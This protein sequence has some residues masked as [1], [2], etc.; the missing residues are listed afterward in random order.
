[1]LM[2]ITS[3]DA[4]A[5]NGI[6]IL[7]L[8][9]VLIKA[10][11]NG[12]PV[13]IVSNHGEP[14]WFQSYFAE[15]GVQFLQVRGRQDGT[16][17]SKNAKKFELRPQDTIV[18][19]ANNADVAMGKN[20][21][22]VLVAAGW[23]DDNA[24]SSLGIRIDSAAEFEMVLNLSS[25][26]NGGWW[27]SSVAQS[28]YSVKALINLSGYGQTMTQQIFARK[29]TNA[30]KTGGD[31]LKALLVAT[32][33][34]L[35]VEGFDGLNDQF[36][37]VYPSSGSSNNDS[38]VL[39]DFTHRLRTTVSRV[40]VARKGVPLFIRHKRSPKRSFREGGLRTDPTSQI[41]TIHL[42]P[43]YR[44]TI[45]GRNVIVVDDC[46]T[47]GVSIGV[48]A[49]FL[50]V[51]GAKSTVG[52]ALGKFGNQSRFYNIEI[53]SDPFKPI[54]PGSWESRSS[55]LQGVLFGEAQNTLREIIP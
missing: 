37:G 9:Q 42:N 4:I 43:A 23:S 6:P 15:T 50:R 38:E 22:A 26:W 55:L 12:N 5:P 30:V 52:V 45:R 35:L 32:T 33:R 27:F 31:R 28:F 20:G 29:V 19:A 53:S 17:I 7:H 48:A 1:M 34:S 24:V 36:W 25:G 40:Q 46:T 14:K 8:I 18:L 54:V 13:G 47:Y 2:I 51:A 21:R 3:P 44:K 41:E 10:R 16:I 39:S 49:A 11:S